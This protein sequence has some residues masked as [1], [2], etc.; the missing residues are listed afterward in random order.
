MDNEIDLHDEAAL[1]WV[2]FW[3][4][5]PMKTALSSFTLV[6][7]TSVKKLAIIFSLLANNS[8]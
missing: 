5:W 2:I 7:Q 4:F 6:L 3:R 8:C 1:N